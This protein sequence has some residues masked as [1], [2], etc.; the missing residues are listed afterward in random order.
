MGAHRMRKKGTIPYDEIFRIPFILRL[1][2]NSHAG[3]T[4]DALA[5]NVSLPGTLVDAAGLEVPG[6]FKGGTMMPVVRGEEAGPDH[7]F[8]EHYGAYWGIHPFRAIRTREWKYVR[9]YGADSDEELYHLMRDQ[10][11]ITNLAN[12]PAY[13]ETRDHLR[14]L[15]D[16][17]WEETNGKDLAYY[18]SEAFKTI[19]GDLESLKAVD[20][21]AK[22]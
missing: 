9:Y 17:W 4:A 1:P 20:T 13:G 22:S 2:R 21:K 15:V 12:Q 19:G 5:V 10:S 6:E 7:I 11:E 16:A 14:R 3:S 8:F 18:E